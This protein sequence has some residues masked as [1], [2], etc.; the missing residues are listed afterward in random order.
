MT[1]T[2]RPVLL[3]QVIAAMVAPGFKARR[4]NQ[5]MP[6]LGTVDG[7]FVDATFGR[8]GHS[9][10]LLPYLSATARLFVLDK[11][12]TAFEV[13]QQLQA[14]D[15]RVVPIHSGFEHLDRSLAEHQVASVDGVMMDLGV[16]SPQLDEAQRGFSFTHDGPLD[17]RMNN[18]TG[19]T[20]AQWLATASINDMKEVL[21][22]YGEER[23]AIQIA[24]AIATRRKS[25]PLQTTH[26]LAQLVS[27]VVPSRP[28]AHHP[29][30]RTFQAIRIYINRELEALQAALPLALQL[31][32][33]GGRLAVIS[34]HSLE[35]RIVKRFI[36]TGARPEAAYAHLPLTQDQLPHPWLKSL[37]RVLPAQDEIDSNPRSRSAVLR[38]AERTER[39]LGDDWRNEW[40]EVAAY[41]ES[42]GQH[43][44]RRRGR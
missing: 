29:A 21:H 24:K 41:Y 36:S 32:K 12:P 14:Q 38:V 6:A 44:S 5:A 25:S 7:D 11:D 10:A 13:A 18:R 43:F 16:S 40:R 26:D 34:F 9:R 27:R 8:G 17:M 30:T 37:G 1:A 19:Q 42:A 22:Y 35:D 4:A 39:P 2:H 15:P 28:K 23:H 31:L 20:A 33:A 3:E